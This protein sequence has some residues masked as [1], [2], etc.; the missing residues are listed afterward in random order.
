[1][2]SLGKLQHC[3]TC[4]DSFTSLPYS[5]GKWTRFCSLSCATRGSRGPVKGGVAWH[6]MRELYLAHPKGL[7]SRDLAGLLGRPVSGIA[8]F[9][10]GHVH[11]NP[12]VFN[13][14]GEPAWHAPILLRYSLTPHGYEI[15]KRHFGEP[16]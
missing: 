9:F 15:A 6:A 8:H 16:E 3:S 10:T 5:R 7:T 11:S 4:G 14:V 1:M 13:A 12:P 2:P